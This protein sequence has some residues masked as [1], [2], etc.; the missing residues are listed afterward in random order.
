VAD[1]RGLAVLP[2]GL[3]RVGSLRKLRPVEDSELTVDASNDNTV[4]IDAKSGPIEIQNED[5][6]WD[7]DFDPHPQIAEHES[8]FDE[9][10]AEIIDPSELNRIAS[11][12]LEGIQQDEM[13]RMEWL[14]DRAEGMRLLGLKLKD[15]RASIDTSTALEG[16]S[17]VDHPMLLKAVLNFWA[18]ASGEMLPAEGPV[19]VADKLKEDGTKDQLAEALEEDLNYYLTT[20]ATEYYPDSSRALLS[21]GFGGM[22]VKKVYNCPLRQRPVS[23]SI[24]IANFIVS[25]AATDLRNSG[26][27]THVITMRPSVLKRM[28]LAGAYRDVSLTTPSGPTPNP[29][30]ETVA[31]I[32]GVQVVSQQTEDRD[33]TIYECYCELDIRGFEDKKAREKTG[34]ALP[35]RVVIDKDSQ[36]V[37]EIR[38][39]WKEED[40][41]KTGLVNFVVFVLIPGFGFYG[42]GLLN[43]LGN[44]TKAMSAAWRETLDAGMFANFPG[45]VYSKVLGRQNTNEFR[46]PPGGGVGFQHTGA[47]IRQAVMPLPYKDVSLAFVQFQDKIVEQADQ[48]A[49]TTQVA[50]AEGRQDA[51]VGTTLAMIEQATKVEKAT[52]K[53]LWRAQCQEFDLLKECFR[54][55]PGSFVKALR[56]RGKTD[57]DEEKFLAALNDAAVVPQADPNT[58]SHMH[59]LLKAM[60]LVQL[61]KQYPGVLDQPSVVESV[62]DMLKLGDYQALKAKGGPGGPSPQQLAEMAKLQMQSRQLDDKQEDRQFKAWV[63]TNKVNLAKFEAQQE[64]LQ[65]QHEAQ[66]QGQESRDQALDRAARLHEGAVDLREREI[67]THGDVAVE[68]IRA[69]AETLKRDRHE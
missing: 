15:P 41:T 49:G 3:I 27:Y 10:L 13:S 40:E 12:V 57:W 54:E 17:S 35:Y 5:G 39:N 34:L 14:S 23:E 58:P 62:I 37:L 22:V 45:F 29:V 31:D 65:R 67:E 7:I 52:H 59:R 69:H 33:Y 63:E 25:N 43:I 48:L 46:V 11:H 4:T 50:V 55:N 44:S 64:A 18:N 61:D 1:D 19:K 6:S 53:E 2:T 51:P 24:D 42:I 8:R 36:Q 47:D 60:G 26:R 32:Q 38:R 66:M 21:T 20:I 28:Q 9:N 56:K 68:A 16:M 30:T